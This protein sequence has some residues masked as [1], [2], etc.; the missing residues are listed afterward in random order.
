MEAESVR[1]EIET[2]SFSVMAELET[3]IR[4]HRAPRAEGIGVP[5]LWMAVLAAI[6]H[7]VSVNS[8][9]IQAPA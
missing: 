4:A 8:F 2:S 5:R 6:K 7:I 1:A 9:T 3:R